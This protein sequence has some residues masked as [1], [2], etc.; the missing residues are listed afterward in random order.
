MTGAP[1]PRARQN[2]PPV[3]FREAFK[4]CFGVCEV[5]RL[6]AGVLDD[7]S[8][9]N[10]VAKELDHILP[11]CLGGEPTLENSAYLCRECHAE[12]TRLDAAARRKRNRHRVREH[13]PKSGWFQG[14]SRAL[15]GGGKIHAR[16]FDRRF[17]RK[18]DGTV[19]KR[20]HG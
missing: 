15:K 18:L 7:R 9:C 12:K 2:F 13:R 4:R 11:D 3:V 5:H 20:R 14:K 6:P 1:E 19:V 8:P 17:K 10:G 16:E